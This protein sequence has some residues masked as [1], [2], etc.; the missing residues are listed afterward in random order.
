VSDHVAAESSEK[1]PA[2]RVDEGEEERLIQGL[3]F[4]EKLIVSI[5]ERLVLEKAS[6]GVNEHAR[7][8]RAGPHVFFGLLLSFLFSILGLPM[9]AG[10]DWPDNMQWQTVEEGKA[11][12]KWE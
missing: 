8:L 5:D 3:D 7:V 4:E 12:D 11:K 1:P 9:S 10:C 2:S 6:V